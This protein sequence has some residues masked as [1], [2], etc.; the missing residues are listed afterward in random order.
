VPTYDICG[1]CGAQ[2][3]YSD[4]TLA[5]C[6]AIR[7]HWVEAERCAFWSWPTQKPPANWSPS[8]QLKFIPA[9]FRTSDDE[10]LIDIAAEY[11]RTGLHLQ[12]RRRLP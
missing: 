3:G 7:K 9:W 4:D 1:C 6:H 12:R 8:S 5:G 11:E 2:Y 10:R